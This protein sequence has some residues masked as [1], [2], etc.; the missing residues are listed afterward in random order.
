MHCPQCGLQQASREV[1]Y[2]R[3][4]GLSLSEMKDLLVKDNDAQPLKIQSPQ[5]S[6]A[7]NQGLMLLLI[8]LVLAVVTALLHD[9]NLMPKVYGKIVAA[10]FLLA[11]LVRMFSPYFLGKGTSSKEQGVLSEPE[12]R[13][14]TSSLPHRLTASRSIPA[15]DLLPRQRDT[16]EMAQPPSVT[17]RTTKLL[18]ESQ[19]HN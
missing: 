11:G 14:E 6:S 2:C 5:L 16:S 10:V 13:L 17:E 4:C 9:L 8:S 7:F 12:I 19:G 18:D 1:R 3:G 15:S